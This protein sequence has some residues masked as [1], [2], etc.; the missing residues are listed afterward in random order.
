[1]LV[2]LYYLVA[3]M[4][5]RLCNPSSSMG[6][7][8]VPIAC[9][10]CRFCIV[11]CH[12][13]PPTLWDL[14]ALPASKPLTMTCLL[15]IIAL[16]HRHYPCCCLGVPNL[17]SLVVLY[18]EQLAT[19]LVFVHLMFAFD[20]FLPCLDHHLATCLACHAFKHVAHIF[21]YG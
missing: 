18:H 2:L 21:Q 3:E 6:F 16:M 8:D 1:M 14:H 13:S 12:S 19:A 17:V 5:I 15:C 4:L 9:V 10:A 7:I 20:H 11:G